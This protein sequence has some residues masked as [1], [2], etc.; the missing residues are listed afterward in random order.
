MESWTRVVEAG[1]KATTHSRK[2]ERQMVWVVGSCGNSVSGQL[3]LPVLKGFMGI[4]GSFYIL[5][6]YHQP[7]T[8]PK[9]TC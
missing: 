7:L 9:I 8:V 3:F 5:L 4:L 2:L 6:K 1:E